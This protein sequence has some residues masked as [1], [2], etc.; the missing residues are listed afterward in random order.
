[1]GGA[2]WRE[3]GVVWA[4]DTVRGGAD[5]VRADLVEGFG[6][7]L[8]VLIGFAA[9]ARFGVP[10]VFAAGCFWGV[11]GSVAREV[12]LPAIARR[13]SAVDRRRSNIYC[14]PMGL[15]ALSRGLEISEMAGAGSF[16]WEP[17]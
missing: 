14:T 17:G 2:A 12:A 9:G 7:W 10:E 4:D 1:M 16:G 11:A 15:T 8:L 13:R 5:L 3:M 6:L